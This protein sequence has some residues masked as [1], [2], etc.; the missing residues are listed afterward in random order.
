MINK[1][2][3]LRTVFVL[4]TCTFSYFNKSSFYFNIR[5]LIMYINYMK[6]D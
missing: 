3:A 5:G 1:I 2:F 6:Y 4:I